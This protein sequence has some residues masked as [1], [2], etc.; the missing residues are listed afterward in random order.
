MAKALV[1]LP[2]TRSAT[3]IMSFKVFK[4]LPLLYDVLIWP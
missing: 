4:G 1:E 2:I 3:G